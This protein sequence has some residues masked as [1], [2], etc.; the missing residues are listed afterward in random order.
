MTDVDRL[1]DEYIREHQTG[2][3]ADPLEYLARV[4]GA[5][6]LELEALIDGYLAHAPRQ[7]PD[8]SEYAGSLS[9]RIVEALSPSIAGVSGLWPTV[10]PELRN[11]A[12]IRRGELVARL[13]A[14]LGAS[15]REAKV[16][17]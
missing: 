1:L 13:A 12:R 15:D 3:D 5:D 9:E 16:A 14:A 7:R 4:K 11:R 8:P 10:L 2:G 6:R 17:D